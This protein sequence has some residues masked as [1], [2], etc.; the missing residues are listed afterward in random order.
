MKKLF[1]YALLSAGLVSCNSAATEQEAVNM[2]SEI[3]EE[4]VQTKDKVATETAAAGGL[5]V[6]IAP[7]PANRVEKIPAKIIKTANLQFQVKDVD[8]SHEQIAALLKKYN[9][10]FANDNKTMS[11]YQIDDNLTIRV[12]P[13][14][15]DALIAELMKESIYTNSKSITAD[16]VTSQFVDL[17]ARLK[18]KKEVEQRYLALLKEAHKVS[19]ILEVEQQLGQIREEIEAMEG[20]F[21]LLND[22]INYS[23]ISVN[24]YEKL[25]YTPEPE[26]G[27]FSDIQEAFVRGWRGLGEFFVGLVRVWPFLLIASVAVFFVVRKIRQRRKQNA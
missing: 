14:N 7:A 22:Q 5:D 2:K 1:L 26:S 9:A 16:D 15:F 25:A 23:T 6:S 12:A 10:Y 20:Q 11:S 17:Q 4:S 24:M 21:K 3:S 18:T 13:E 27:F 8:K 19:D